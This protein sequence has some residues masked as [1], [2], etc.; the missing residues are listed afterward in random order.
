MQQ[1]ARK[2]E[3]LQI[4]TYI[5]EVHGNVNVHR[6]KVS[7]TSNIDRDL[8]DW[9]ND[10]ATAVTEATGNRKFGRSTVLN[11]AIKFY[12]HF[13]AYSKKWFVT[14]RR[15]YSSLTCWIKRRLFVFCL[16]HLCCF[17]RRR[18]YIFATFDRPIVDTCNDF[19]DLG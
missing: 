8:S 1:T 17:L 18:I 4:E 3:Q 7:A 15:F 14:K 12:R 6:E 2:P 13:F 16:R 10:I 5:K 11:E 9:A 19:S